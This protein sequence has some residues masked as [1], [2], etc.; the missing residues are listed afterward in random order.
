MSLPDLSRRRLLQ[1][2]TAGALTLAVGAQAVTASAA[3]AATADPYDA[4]RLRWLAL[5]TGTGFD[6]AA[7]PFATALRG[8][9]DRARAQ[10]QTMAPAAGSLWPDLPLGSVSA[11]ITGSFVRLR[12]MALAWA[13]PGTGLT[14]D[15][16]LGAA[17]GTGLD[18]L[19]ATAYT[20]T[21]TAYDNWWDWQI[22]SP[23]ALLDAAV[24]AFPL[25]TATQLASYGAAVDRSVP[26][27]RVAAYSGTSTGANRVDLCRVL[28]LRGVLGRSS[29]KLATAAGA[30]S[31]VFPF[32]LTG[33]GLYPD[34]SF[35]QHTWVPYTGSYG[36]V[37]L[38]GL[39]RLF[40]LLAG[41]A[42]EVVDP[43]R[44]NVFD[45]VDSA[46]APF[47]F[48]GLVMDAVSGRAISRG[49]QRSDLLHLQ[50]DD[51][52][53]GHTIIG[54]ILRL[55]ESGAAPAGQSAAWRA[56]V[57][58][59]IARDYY[60]PYL[61]DAAVDV[62]ELA[63]AQG[64]LAD[65]AVT[66]A[67][68][69]VGARVFAMDRA[70]V[71]R[72]G[73]AAAVSMCSA[74]T[75]FYET[76][77]GENLRGWHTN[78]GLLSWWNA[79][80]GNGQYADAFWPT[81]NPYR[82]PGT[83]V[84]TKALADAAGGA[85]G[86]ARPDSVWAGGASDG[87]Y[88][89]LGQAVRGL[90][91]TLTGWKSW[92]L[93][94]DS[95]VCLGAGLSCADGV[96]VETVVDNRNL[97]ASG[98][99]ALTVDGVVQP[100]TLGWSQQFTGARSIA[101][102]GFGGYVF[103]GGATVRALREARSGSWHDV[104]FG[105]TTDVLTRRYLTLWFDH[106]TDP[107]GASYAYLLLPGAD[108]ATTAA[109][110]ASPTVTVLANSASVQAVSDA[111]SGVTAANFRVAG[112]VGGI[113]VSAPCSVLVR[114]SGGVLTVA[115]AD[116]SRTAAVVQVTVDRPGYV[117]AD[118]AA[119]VSVLAAG[120]SVRLLAELGGTQGAS[121]TVTLR[122]SG[123][124]AAASAVLLAPVQDTYLRDGSYA[125][126]NYGTATVL[127]V[128]NTN[129]AGSG[130]SRRALL[131]FDT[132]QVAGPVRRAVLWVHGAVADSG[133]TETDL[134]AFATAADAWQETAATWNRSPA[135]GA[136]LGAGRISTAADW[137]ALDVTA[138][139]SASSLLTLTVGQS[140]GRVGLA[141]NLNSRENPAFP[142]VLQVV[143]D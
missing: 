29:A 74:R 19:V 40:A 10:Q 16:A 24:L 116:P 7:E 125:D 34:G 85:W 89:A 45:A 137:V 5:L 48:N 21:A 12:T 77:N 87:T 128:K 63:R 53:R 71:R 38:G 55:A 47:L 88:A 60:R 104:N 54:H 91:S 99:H 105:G 32:V 50:Q 122:R 98:T 39:S 90:S 35:V 4:L 33:D 138:A 94:D 43:Q 78:S 92:F 65:G 14:G 83:T 123:S 84:S 118:A 30:L 44:Q 73:W 140:A 69:P 62:P 46:Y 1:A 61:S 120:P 142:P 113:T 108:A 3:A 107:S 117:S 18:H 112:S 22:G 135:P 59:W 67:P 56:A 141:V 27:S 68:E 143:T 109:R 97:G 8:L 95:V 136:A 41:S 121:R 126:A 76:G 79:T 37:L 80:T 72:A 28:A 119:G 64:L 134:Q 58:G 106:G 132:S 111:A 66:A 36:E 11:N 26:D 15:A 103:P 6:P 139:V 130:Y 102:A 25:L 127:T 17:V 42:W 82:L 75:T 110:A 23:Q 100:A 93:L 115:V 52:G 2:T 96:P 51:H 70:V 129:T 131:G 86:T 81:V 133:G 20:A 31:P 101:L 13:Q 124:A 114:E 9:G 57:K 49:L